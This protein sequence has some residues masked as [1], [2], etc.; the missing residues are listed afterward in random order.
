MASAA[1]LTSVARC[2]A[3]DA[4]LHSTRARAGEVGDVAN[5]GAGIIPQV[6]SAEPGLGV[7]DAVPT[8][9]PRCSKCILSGRV[10]TDHVCERLRIVGAEAILLAR[11]DAI[12][13]DETR[14]W[15]IRRRRARTRRRRWT[16]R[17]WTGA[18]WWRR[19][20]A[21]RRWRWAGTRG[22]RRWRRACVGRKRRRNSVQNGRTI[23][24]AWVG[25]AETQILRW[26]L[27]YECGA[28]WAPG[29]RAHHAGAVQ[30]CAIQRND[31]VVSSVAGSLRLKP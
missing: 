10:E 8:H 30:R 22:R 5:K 3:A 1:R 11:L 27:R 20:G 4:P 2:S 19:A 14:G 9:Q 18:G 23:S 31:H 26:A 17:R 6:R 12:L 25:C 7:V 21:G 29:G 24:A 13:G 16:G 28:D 15:R